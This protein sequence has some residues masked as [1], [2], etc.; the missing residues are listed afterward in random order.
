MKYVLIAISVLLCAG[1][2]YRIAQSAP[3]T[4]AAEPSVSTPAAADAEPAQA[5]REVRPGFREYRNTKYKIS[6]LIPED[7]K[8]TE[9]NEGNEAMTITFENA[10]AAQGFQIFIVP[11]G[12]PQI[13]EVRFKK[14]EPSGMRKDPRDITIDGA[15]A[16]SFYSTNLALGET[17]E[18]WFI[19]GGYLY[20]VT[21]LKP[22]DAWLSQIM[23]TWKWI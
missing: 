9:F 14:D 8:V 1:V 4:P 2:A 3:R 20:E 6:L 7:L 5:A 22:L 16:S 15:T 21:T 13:S 10:T 19:H 11:Y 18:I 12:L 23:T 17:A